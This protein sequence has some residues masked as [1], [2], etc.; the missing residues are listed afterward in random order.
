MKVSKEF[1]RKIVK[2]FLGEGWEKTIP[3]ILCEAFLGEVEDGSVIFQKEHE[4]SSIL[5]LFSGESEGM[6]LSLSLYRDMASI[7]I[8]KKDEK[9]K[10]SGPYP[11][12]FVA[13]IT[14]DRANFHA[15]ANLHEEGIFKLDDKAVHIM[16]RITKRITQIR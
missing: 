14:L 12:H 9:M 2:E 3:R 13:Q 6:I 15:R 16:G 1:V 5:R 11:A 10:G 7:N 8:L 4:D